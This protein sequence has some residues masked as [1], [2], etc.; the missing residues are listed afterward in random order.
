MDSIVWGPPFWFTLHTI[1]MTYPIY[2]NTVTR[3]KYYEFISN[4]PLFLP[5]PAI[6]NHFAKLLDE[7]PLEPYISSRLSFMKWVHF[8]HNKVNS[9]LDKPQL[10]FYDFLQDYH[11]KYKPKTEKE[12]EK[13]K[14]KK[15]YIEI[16]CIVALAMSV[17]YGYK[18]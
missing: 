1:S 14:E 3:K 8:I 16:A 10:S 7:Y 15:R 12:E 13:K 11:D 2:P 18:N 17:L 6:G 4:L 9:Y 5:A